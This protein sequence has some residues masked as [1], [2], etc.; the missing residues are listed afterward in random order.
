MLIHAFNRV[1]RLLAKG[2]RGGHDHRGELSRALPCGFQRR[3]SFIGVPEGGRCYPCDPSTTPIP[4]PVA[5]PS[6]SHCL[7]SRI[8]RGANENLEHNAGIRRKA[9][10][11]TNSFDVA[12][13]A[14]FTVILINSGEDLDAEKAAIRTLLAKSVDGLIV[15]PAK[16]SDVDD[17]KEANRSGRPLVLL[18]RGSEALDVDT[19]IANDQYAAEDITGRLI[20]TWP[21]A[22]R[23]PHG[24]S[25][26]PVC[27][28]H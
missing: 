6:R 16:E 23:L 8:S 3:A 17:L 4:H 9:W 22:H 1:D 5:P 14:G 11:L 18:D 20:G 10:W 24:L 28:G 2:F 21:P 13:Q 19:V 15:S 7:R 12:R 27:L 25:S 26:P